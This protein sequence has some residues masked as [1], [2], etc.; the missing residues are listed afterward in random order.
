M[1]AIATALLAAPGAF[2]KTF[3]IAGHAAAAAWLVRSAKKLQPATPDGEVTGEGLRAYYKQIWN[4]F[5]FEYA[6]Y[7]FI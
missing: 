5:Y 2:R 4:L 1:G 7:P 6:M 3:M